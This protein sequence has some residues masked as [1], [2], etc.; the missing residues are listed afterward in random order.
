MTPPELSVVCRSCGSEVSPYVTECPYC[1]TRVRKRAPKLE[2]HGDELTAQESRRDQR[3]RK[4]LER[5]ASRTG[6][7]LGER[8]Y[9]TLALIVVPALA[10][11]VSQAG[12]F[13]LADAGVFGSVDGDWWR[14][15]SA[16]LVYPDVGYLFAASIGIGI[17]GH[18]L[19]QRLGTLTVLLL[20]IACGTLGMLAADGL[21]GALAGDGPI[22]A[23]G[24]N[25]IALGLLSAWSVLRWR[26]IRARREDDA[27]VIGVAIV[28]AA[29]VFLP[30]FEAW[31]NVFAGVAGGLV[32]VG[33]GLAAA[34]TLR[35]R[36]PG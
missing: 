28:A 14:Y 2:R 16:P 30:A 20:A 11:L 17:F 21:E 31:A 7:G 26:D 4:R 18:A 34:L 32:G 35:E 15:F 10:L 24:G 25:G 6:S 3:R 19:E 5:V 8:P 1:G 12:G 13:S 33:C 27:E 9:A 22:L 23:A 36:R 29:L